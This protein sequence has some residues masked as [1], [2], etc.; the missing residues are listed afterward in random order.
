MMEPEDDNRNIVVMIA[1]F[2]EWCIKTTMF[3]LNIDIVTRE[4]IS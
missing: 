1:E 4:I 2:F 3:T